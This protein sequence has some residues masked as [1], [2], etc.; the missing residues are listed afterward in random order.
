MGARLCRQLFGQLTSIIAQTAAI[1][2]NI[3]GEDNVLEHHSD[4]NIEDIK[5]DNFRQMTKLATENWD[6]PIIVTTNVQ[7][8]E[9]MFDNRPSKCRKLHNI[10]NSVI[11]LDEV[12]TLPSEFLLPIVDSLKTYNKLFN[13]SILL[14]TASQPVLSGEIK[15]CNYTVRLEGIDKIT[16]IIP[17]NF[18]LHK[19]LHR[20][21]ISVDNT[22]STY[23][24]VANFMK[25]HTRVL[26]IVNTR[27]D[28]KKI[29][30]LLPNEGI[31]LHLSKMMCPAHIKQTITQLKDALKDNR[32]SI[33]RVVS[34][35]LIEAGVDIDFPIVLRQEA[36]LDSVLQ[37]AGRC[38]REGN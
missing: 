3:F 25:Q 4:F 34:T 38:N 36:G 24:D 31:T 28:A 19:K 29:F 1:L 21:E 27:N 22:I 8:F 10:C 6:Y 33:I 13:T 32:K 2:K 7:L 15:G 12:Q 20:A 35:Q 30:D 18:N 11:I 14:T 23:G 17:L 16:E 37:A 5:D 26:C 9:S